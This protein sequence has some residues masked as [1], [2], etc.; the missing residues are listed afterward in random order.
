[1][2]GRTTSATPN[3]RFFSTA[4]AE[5]PTEIDVYSPG[6]TA[7]KVSDVASALPPAWP[8]R[9]GYTLSGWANS[10]MSTSDV[11]GQFVADGGVYYALWK[12]DTPPTPRSTAPFIDVPLGAPFEPDIAWLKDQKITGGF[13]DGSF[14]PT[15]PVTREAVAAF[16]YRQA[17]N[18][19]DAPAPSA[20]PFPDVPVTARFA[21]DIAW[22]KNQRVTTGYAEGGFHPTATISRAAAAAFLYRAAHDGTNPEIPTAKPFTDVPTSSPFAGDIAW[23]KAQHI[24]TGYPDGTYRPSNHITREA[25]AAFLHRA[26]TS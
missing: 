8:F 15:T 13:A 10:S 7:A 24:T 11:S 4:S 23:L 17:H 9:N 20:A 16:L 22:L 14:R 12:A 25:V 6:V 18:G 26:A 5:S 1:V 3:A 21:G 2:D 19:M